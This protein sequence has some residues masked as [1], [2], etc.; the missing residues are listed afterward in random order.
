MPK[1]VKGR[2]SKK[3]KTMTTKFKLRRSIFIGLLLLTFLSASNVSAKFWGWEKTESYS[4]A[5][6]DG[7]VCEVYTRYVFW[8][9]V[10]SKE[11][12]GPCCSPIE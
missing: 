5:Y 2:L 10:D 3:C 12:C 7:T 11:V 1:C 8:I 6:T 9:A 4:K